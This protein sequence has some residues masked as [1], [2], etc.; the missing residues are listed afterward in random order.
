VA[1]LRGYSPGL[2]RADL[3]AGL[4]VAAVAVPQAMADAAVAG[5]PA[6]YGVYTA[7][8]LTAVAA[9]FSSSRHLVHGPTTAVTIALLCTLAPIPA[10]EK[11]AA[12][13]VL[14]LLV[15]LVQIAC[16]IFRVADLARYVS[17]AALFGF[18]LGIS[19]ALVIDQSRHLLGQT[20]EGAVGDSVVQRL[21]GTLSHPH[22]ANPWTLGVGLGTVGLV[23]GLQRLGKRLGVRLPAYLMALGLMAALAASCN[24]EGKG[25]RLVGAVPAAAPSLQVPA[26]SWDRLRQLAPSAVAVGLLGL[27]ESLAIARALAQRS[28]RWLDVRQQCLSDGMANLAGS[29]FGCFPGAGSF[30]RSTLNYEAGARTQWAAV[31]GAIAVAAAMLPVA[32]LARFVPRAAL[33]ALLILAAWRLIDRRQ[34]LDYLRRPGWGTA[35]AAATAA[36]TVAVS[37]EWAVLAG[38]GISAVLRKMDSL[39]SNRGNRADND[40]ADKGFQSAPP[41]LIAGHAMPS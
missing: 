39:Q 9:L 7:V 8:V 12:A 17:P 25:V 21:W 33:A 29:F 2:L 28:G 14:A 4:T 3:A 38:A 20:A 23:M 40:E 24:L 32:P 16:R 26:V 6:H 41:T 35:G 11:P 34:L 22:A 19:A 18:M 36:V 30:T 10:A 5:L 15:G 27:F 13:A 31:F 37:V 1:A